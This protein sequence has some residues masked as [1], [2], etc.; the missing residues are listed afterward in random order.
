MEAERHTVVVDERKRVVAA[1]VRQV[2]TFTDKEIRAD[3]ALG[4]LV[5]KGEGLNITDLNL[6]TGR[7]V[8]EGRFQALSYVTEKGSR[9]RGGS[10]NLLERLF[11]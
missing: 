7:L 1:G 11:K 4:Y 8:V 3:T 6:E 5:L 2:D 10:R 9:R